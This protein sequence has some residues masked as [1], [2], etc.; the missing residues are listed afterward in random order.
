ML[1]MSG[2]AD[3]QLSRPDCNQLK[4]EAEVVLLYFSDYLG[5]QYKL[6]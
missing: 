6:Y 3:R 4:T 2:I 5:Q 1:P